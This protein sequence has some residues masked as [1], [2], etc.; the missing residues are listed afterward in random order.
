MVGFLILPSI[1][2]NFSSIFRSSALFFR[3]LNSNF[4]FY[5]IIL[6]PKI[7]YFLK[8]LGFSKSLNPVY[9]YAGIA[10]NMLVPEVRSVFPAATPIVPDLKPKFCISFPMNFSGE[11]SASVFGHLRRPPR[12]PPPPQGRSHHPLHRHAHRLANPSS[13]H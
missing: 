7:N 11:P 13:F 9:I 2:R 5:V 1:P 8:Y 12:T 3:S 4:R 10:L 6:I